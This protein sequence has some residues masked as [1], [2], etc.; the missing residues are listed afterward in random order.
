M[1]RSIMYPTDSGVP[2]RYR[3]CM[4]DC[5]ARNDRGQFVDGELHRRTLAAPVSRQLLSLTERNDVIGAAM[6]NEHGRLRRQL[7]DLLLVEDCLRH[8]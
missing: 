4:I 2:T 3:R 1:K 8:G 6:L 7:A 5:H